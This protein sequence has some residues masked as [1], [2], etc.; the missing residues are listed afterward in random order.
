MDLKHLIQNRNQTGPRPLSQPE[1]QYTKEEYAALKKAEREE[2]WARVDAQADKVFQNG[3]ELKAFLTFMAECTPQSTRNLLIL[4]EQ[5][6]AV[7]HPRTFEKWAEAG[8]SLRS[9]VTGYTFFAEQEY[10]G[11]DGS[12]KTGYTITKAFDISQTRG[13]QPTPPQSHLP[14]ELLAAMIENIPVPLSI[15]DDLPEGIQAQYVPK[16]RIIYVRDGLDENT[17]FCAI[18]REQAHAYYDTVGSGYYRQAFTAQGYCAAYA[19]AHKFGIDTSMFNFDRV[20]EACAEMEPQEKRGFISTVKHAVY[21]INRG[22]QRSLREQAQEI[23]PDD[24][25]LAAKKQARSAKAKSGPEA[26]R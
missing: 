17:A 11:E 9:G 21:S 26:G 18:A 13:P 14:E 25:S 7:T 15:S 24:F 16:Q 5:D 12:R 19:A 1:Q 20:C 8:R 10:T 3:G 6:P 2:L 4:F 23:R 22:I